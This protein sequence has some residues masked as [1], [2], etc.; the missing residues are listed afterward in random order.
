MRRCVGVAPFY[1]D[2]EVRV[3]S[4]KHMDVLDQPIRHPTQRLSSCNVDEQSSWVVRV[5]GL[6]AKLNGSARLQSFD[7]LVGAG[8][9]TNAGDKERADDLAVLVSL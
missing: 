2:F 5:I 4:A 3:L 8:V 6:I 7:Q 9:V 1:D